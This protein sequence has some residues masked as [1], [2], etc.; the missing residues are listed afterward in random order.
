MARP[1]SMTL[2]KAP[3]RED[4]LYKPATRPCSDPAHGAAIIFIHGLGDDADGLAG[5]ECS[6]LRR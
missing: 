4:P 2:P 5:K 3:G 1:R 6:S